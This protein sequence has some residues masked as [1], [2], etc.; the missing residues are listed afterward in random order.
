MSNLAKVY[1]S[2][3]TSKMDLKREGGEK[4][5]REGSKPPTMTGWAGGG[6]FVEGGNLDRIPV[7]QEHK[8]SQIYKVYWIE[9][10]CRQT[11]CLLL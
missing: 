10:F 7:P 2:F 6:S 3:Q 4:S 8:I 5:N 1:I 9:S 11:T